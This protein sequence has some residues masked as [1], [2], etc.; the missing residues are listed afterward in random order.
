MT[1]ALPT[2]FTQIHI[3]QNILDGEWY[4]SKTSI[5]YQTCQPQDAPG[6]GFEF[7]TKYAYVQSGISGILDG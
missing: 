4:K 6:V 2:S 7:T 1:Q 3:P 5:G